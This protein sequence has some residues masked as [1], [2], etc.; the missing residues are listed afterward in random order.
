V[1][2]HR[3]FSHVCC[4]KIKWHHFVKWFPCLPM[5]QNTAS[6]LFTVFPNSGLAGPSSY[7]FWT[8]L[9]L[10]PASFTFIMHVSFSL[11]SSRCLLTE[12]I[13]PHLL[14]PST[15]F[16]IVLWQNVPVWCHALHV[17]APSFGLHY[18]Y[19]CLCHMTEYAAAHAAHS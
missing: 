12:G 3:P 1:A 4:Q 15:H 8:T 17:V 7:H 5:T 16:Q 11:Q 10:M 2:V 9:S 6:S 14:V 19:W 18:T 13:T